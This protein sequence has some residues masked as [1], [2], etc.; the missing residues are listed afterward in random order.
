MVG[1]REIVAV[2][3]KV[4]RTENEGQHPSPKM[5][6]ACD[7]IKCRFRHSHHEVLQMTDMRKNGAAFSGGKGERERILFICS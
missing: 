6:T 1:T 5:V 7:D 3:Q 4:A 2:G